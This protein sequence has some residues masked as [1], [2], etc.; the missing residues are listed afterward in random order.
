MTDFFEKSLSSVRLETYR[1]IARKDGEKRSERDLYALNIQ[2]SKELY[3]MLSGLEITVRNNFNQACV[4]YAEKKDWF[5]ANLLKSKHKAQINKAVDFLTREKQDSYVL[6]DIIAHLNYG[7]WVN[8]C[9]SPYDSTL[10]RGALYKCFPALGQKPV[11]K[12]IR[13][14]FER[15]LKLRNKIA[16]LEPIIKHEELLIQEY[17][18]ASELLYAMCPKT[19]E[20]FARI[21]DFEEVWD[22]RFEDKL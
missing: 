4:S 3:V 11:R 8:L 16:H 13:Q 9:N 10:W 21:C 18:N 5:S 22:N 17:R 14:K 15:T 2:Y 19:Q 6:D 7:F 20:W 1:E 12:D